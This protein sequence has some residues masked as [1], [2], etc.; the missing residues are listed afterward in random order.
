MSKTSTLFEIFILYK[1][2][3]MYELFDNNKIINVQ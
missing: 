2:Y 1:S 3:M